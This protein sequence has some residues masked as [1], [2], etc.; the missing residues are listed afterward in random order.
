MTRRKSVDRLVEKILVNVGQ[1]LK[2]DVHA[3]MRP[4]PSFETTQ[5]ESTPLFTVVR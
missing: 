5:V 4:V 2:F 3:C 1:S